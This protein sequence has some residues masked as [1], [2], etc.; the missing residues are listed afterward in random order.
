MTRTA[1]LYRAYCATS[2]AVQR[3]YPAALGVFVLGVALE[4]MLYLAVWY[5]AAGQDRIAGYDGTAFVTYYLLVMVANHISYTWFFGEMDRR[6]REGTFSALLLR[7]VHPIHRDIADNLAFKLVTGLLV[8]PLAVGLA[9]T[10]GAWPAPGVTLLLVVPSLVLGTALR[11]V[12]EWTLALTS[13]WT[14]RVAAIGRVYGLVSHFLGGFVAPIA[15]LPDPLR[16]I[17]FT[18][19]FPWLVAFPVELAAGRHTFAAA[20]TGLACQAGWLLVALV[21]HRWVWRRAAARYSAV[22]G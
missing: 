14:T 17:A 19:P 3:R 10:L 16:V 6:V 12:V 11:F 1:E 5:A 2:W 18:T 13:M 4:P 22:S 21:A 9:A 15:A 20:L 8:V 7:P